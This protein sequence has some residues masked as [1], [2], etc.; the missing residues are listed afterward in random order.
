MSHSLSFSK[1]AR[2]IRTACYCEENNVSTS[3]GLEHAAGS[4]AHTVARHASRRGRRDGIGR[5][6]ASPRADGPAAESGLESC[7]CGRGFAC[8]SVWRPA[9]M[10]R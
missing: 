10:S 4:Q 6:A 1:L 9:D 3:E 2:A 7:S 8:G 5:P